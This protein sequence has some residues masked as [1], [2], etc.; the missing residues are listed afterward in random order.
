MRKKKEIFSKEIFQ[1]GDTIFRTLMY[2]AIKYYKAD[3]CNIRAKQ[4][5]EY[6]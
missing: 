4:Y 5:I 6:S 1:K 3:F 2:W